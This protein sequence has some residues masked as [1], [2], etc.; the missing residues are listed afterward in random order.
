MERV[1]G[2]DSDA[3]LSVLAGRRRRQIL[4]HLL[5][6]GAVA[7][8]DLVTH[9]IE[10]ESAVGLDSELESEAPDRGTVA[11]TLHHVDLPVLSEVGLVDYECTRGPV[12][13]TDRARR[14]AP[15]LRAVRRVERTDPPS[16]AK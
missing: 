4:A 13:P 9:L 12:R 15:V 11:G 7:F 16:D 1:D 14:Y 5:A 8:E 3:V 2:G 10:Q 6:E